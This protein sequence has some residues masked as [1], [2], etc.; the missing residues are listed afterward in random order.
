MLVI[1]DSKFPLVWLN[2]VNNNMGLYNHSLNVENS[3][4]QLELLFEKKVPF[5]LISEN[6]YDKDK[7]HEHTKE[8]KMIIA[9]WMK[10]NKTNVKN[11]IIAQI[12]VI[13]KEKQTILI[14]AFSKTFS[15]FWGFPLII[16]TNRNAAIE[17]A[18][19]LLGRA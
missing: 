18:H 19:E 2:Q 17:K 1:D 9:K 4:S 11:Y 7:D 3:F 10:K 15:K 13:P 8:E 5:I 16:T 6:N 12:Q 14:K